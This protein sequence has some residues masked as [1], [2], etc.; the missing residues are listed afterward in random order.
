M[1]WL[2]SLQEWVAKG[3]HGN[4]VAIALVLCAVSAAIGIAVA[5]QLAPEVVPGAGDRPEPRLL[6]AGTGLRRDLRRRRD[7]PECGA[8]VRSACAA[9][10]GRWSLTGSSAGSRNRRTARRPASAPMSDRAASRARRSRRD[11]S[12]RVGL[13][14]C[15][16]RSADK[17]DAASTTQHRRRA[18]AQWPACRSSTGSSGASGMAA[19]S[20]GQRHQAGADAGARHRRPGRA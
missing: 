12:S 13:L 8:A 1:S 15:G 14:L 11:R 2:S 16:L 3:V 10:C 9:R 17:K 18:P 5:R 6:G 7:R 20:V 4:G 19:M